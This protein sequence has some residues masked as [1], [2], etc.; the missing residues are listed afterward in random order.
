[1]SLQIFFS[2]ITVFDESHL[3]LKW[4][5]HLCISN[6]IRLV[7]DVAAAPLK[8]SHSYSTIRSVL[9]RRNI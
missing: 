2:N 9:Y 1:M 5:D 8:H 6:A 7:I 3:H 4:P